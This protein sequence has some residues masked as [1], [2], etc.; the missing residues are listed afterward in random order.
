MQRRIR[1][2]NNAI[3]KLVKVIFVREILIMSLTG[4]VR[5]YRQGI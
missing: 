1:G 3:K 2:G 5:G 4:E